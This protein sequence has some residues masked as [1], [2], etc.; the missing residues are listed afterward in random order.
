EPPTRERALLR[1]RKR[2]QV[3]DLRE[4]VSN[5]IFRLVETSHDAVQEPLDERLA[6]VDEHRPEIREIADNLAGD[7]AHEISDRSELV[8]HRIEE[9]G[10]GTNDT[11]PNIREERF[12]VVPGSDPDG[13]ND[14]HDG[15]DSRRHD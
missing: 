12:D 13:L 8:F 7:T 14:S 9:P 6:R 1:G 2:E 3:T 11:V 4:P 15:L 10:S 5:K